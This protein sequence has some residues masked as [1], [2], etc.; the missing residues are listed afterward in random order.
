MPDMRRAPNLEKCAQSAKINNSALAGPSEL[1][2][3]LR[4]FTKP[5][6]TRGFSAIVQQSGI[7]C[8]IRKRRRRRAL[9]AQSMTLDSQ[10]LRFSIFVSQ[11][12]KNM[13]STTAKPRRTG[14]MEE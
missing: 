2:E 14:M 4:M 7:P 6:V 3:I 12:D 13:K 11:P 9:P 10:S 8:S 1:S 5:S